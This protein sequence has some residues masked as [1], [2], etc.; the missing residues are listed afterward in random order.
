MG[1]ERYYWKGK[2][3]SEKVYDNRVRQSKVGKSIRSVYGKRNIP[4]LKEDFKNNE[5]EGCRVMH[6]ETLA[7]QMRCK[8]CASV[9]SLEDICEEKRSGLASIFYI[10]CKNCQ[11]LNDVHTSKHHKGAGCR[12]H[13]DTNTKAV[14]GVLNGGMGHTHLNK[15]L[16]ALNIP[17]MHWNT[18]KT[19]EKEVG[20]AI[21]E[22]SQDS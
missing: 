13:Y 9:L 11:S 16:S 21:E 8:K 12:T 6:I 3:V 4:N 10:T 2:R 1:E 14:L 17:E 5:I 19:H 15:F 20:K 22:S 18:F 7:H